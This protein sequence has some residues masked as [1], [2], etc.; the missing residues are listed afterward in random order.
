MKSDLQKSYE[1][2]ENLWNRNEEFRAE[3]CAVWQ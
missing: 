1:E 2:E 3:E